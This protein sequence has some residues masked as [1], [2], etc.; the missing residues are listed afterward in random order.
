MK[1]DKVA[2]PSLARVTG[3]N[4]KALLQLPRLVRVTALE[5]SEAELLE[6]KLGENRFIIG[7]DWSGLGE[8]IQNPSVIALATLNQDGGIES[9]SIS[10]S[11]GIPPT[12]DLPTKQA[13]EAGIE[14][15]RGLIQVQPNDGII[16]CVSVDPKARHLGI[17]GAHMIGQLHSLGNAG[18]SQ[19]WGLFYLSYDGSELRWDKTWNHFQR[20]YGFSEKGRLG[21]TGF[22]AQVVDLKSQGLFVPRSQGVQVGS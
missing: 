15:T 14:G 3:A 2:L 7:N 4:S 6:H 16:M 17:G 19:A 5:P 22:N 1:I 8:V 12:N 20:N 18:C 11:N 21:N 10:A 13:F 9:F